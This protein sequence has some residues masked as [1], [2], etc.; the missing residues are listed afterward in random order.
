M[1]VLFPIHLTSR[2]VRK[3]IQKVKTLPG[4]YPQ[5][6]TNS[7]WWMPQTKAISWD[8]WNKSLPLLWAHP[9]HVAYAT[10]KAVKGPAMPTRLLLTAS[11]ARAEGHSP[12]WWPT[13]AAGANRAKMWSVQ[14]SSPGTEISSRLWRPKPRVLPPLLFAVQPGTVE[15]GPRRSGDL[16]NVLNT[17]CVSLQHADELLALNFS[18]PGS[19]FH[20]IAPSLLYALPYRSLTFRFHFSPLPKRWQLV[21]RYLFCLG[22]IP[23]A[24]SLPSWDR[25]LSCVL[26][27]R[28]H[29]QARPLQQVL[30]VCS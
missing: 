19:R 15:K 17:R 1:T 12:R 25:E 18:Y 28:E 21:P 2:N 3:K 24:L 13:A 14:K 4:W 29:Q 27:H 5:N 30:R 11:N 26:Q 6:V 16:L 9:P 10:L 20:L 23:A 22:A 8:L 7:E